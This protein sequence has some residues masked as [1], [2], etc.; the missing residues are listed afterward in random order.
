MLLGRLYRKSVPAERPCRN[1]VMGEVRGNKSAEI[2]LLHLI[3]GRD[4]RMGK[5]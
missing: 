4:A 2:T 3:P 5:R 1:V